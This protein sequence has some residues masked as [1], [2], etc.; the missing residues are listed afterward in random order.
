MKMIKLSLATLVAVGGFASAA[1]ATPLEE[2]IKGVD[3]S[4]YARYRFTKTDPGSKQHEF[5]LAVTVKTPVN[6]YLQ[7]VGSA[8]VVSKDK[9]RTNTNSTFQLKEAYAV[10]ALGDTSILVGKQTVGAFFTDDMKATGLKVVNTSVPGW[11]FAAIAFD[12]LEEDGDVAIGNFPVKGGDVVYDQRLFGAAAIG[13]M[14]PV[15]GQLWLAYVQDVATMYA[16]ELGFGM[17]MGGVN[18]GITGQFGGTSIDDLYLPA[19]LGGAKA[20]DGMV[21]GI[22]ANVGVSG[23]DLDLGYV[24]AEADKKGVTAISFEDDGGYLN[25][26]EQSI[27]YNAVIGE[28]DIFFL[29]AGAN[30]DKFFVG[31]DFVHLKNTT[32]TS[33]AKANEYVLR[34]G[35][36]YNKN[37]NFKSYFSRLDPDG[38][39][40]ADKFRFEAK[41][42]F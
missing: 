15:N 22:A 36:K 26:G 32:N 35:Y 11:T 5:K 21:Y 13:E 41:Y 34:L 7:V 9:T 18:F 40:N 6:D 27:D 10:V 3:L 30:L 38:G 12:T 42:S 14:G 28:N 39:D 20:N 25:A 16:L 17:D 23:F 24:H 2:S 33:S 1:S 4:G 29:V 19:T 8:N 31:A 37:W